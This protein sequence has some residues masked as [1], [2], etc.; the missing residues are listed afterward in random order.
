MYSCCVLFSSSSLVLLAFN[1]GKVYSEI[2]AFWILIRL[3]FIDMKCSSMSFTSKLSLTSLFFF[4]IQSIRDFPVQPF[5]R[6]SGQSEFICSDSSSNGMTTCSEIPKTMQNGQFCEGD[7][8]TLSSNLT[9]ELNNSCINWNQYYRRCSPSDHNPFLGAISFD[10]I[11][12]AC[13]AIF[14]VCPTLTNEFHIVFD[15]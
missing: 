10:N 6:P 7:L 2:V 5:Y 3:S 12:M 4:L 13:I 14:Q 11:P 9:S 15:F 1:Y 8:S